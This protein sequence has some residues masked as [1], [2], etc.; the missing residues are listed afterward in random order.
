M[1]ISAVLERAAKEKES[2]AGGVE[3]SLEAHAFAQQFGVPMWGDD[4]AIT[5]WLASAAEYARV[6]GR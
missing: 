6:L 1:K 5:I 2:G 3:L 4:V